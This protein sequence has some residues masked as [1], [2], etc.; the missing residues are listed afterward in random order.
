MQTFKPAIRWWAPLSPRIIAHFSETLL[1]HNDRLIYRRG[2]FNKSEVAIP[3]ARIT[4][5]AAE[6][7][8]FDRI[9]GIG[10]F[11]VETAAANISPEL[12][13]TGYPYALRDILARALNAGSS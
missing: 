8:F 9:F 2:I 5:Y 4:N 1:V 6:Q 7:S 12:L 10:N 3:F 13:L 11:R